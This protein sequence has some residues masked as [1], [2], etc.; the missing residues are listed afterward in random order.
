MRRASRVLT[1]LLGVGLWAGGVVLFVGGAHVIG[2]LVV[3][4]GAIA[5]V[6]SLTSDRGEAV[7]ETVWGWFTQ[8]P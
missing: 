2:A 6:L 3:L 5:V 7:W 1:A 8:L 4:L